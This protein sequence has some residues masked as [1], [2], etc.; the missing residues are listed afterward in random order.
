M[1]AAHTIEDDMLE[2][3]PATLVS[4]D[5]VMTAEYQQVREDFHTSMRGFHRFHISSF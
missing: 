2:V 3:G 5:G 1:E 4:F